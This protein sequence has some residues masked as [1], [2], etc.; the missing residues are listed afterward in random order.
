MPDENENAN[1]THQFGIVSTVSGTTG[2]VIQSITA[3]DTAELAEARG[4]NGE[5]LELHKFSVGYRYTV[6]GILKSGAAAGSLGAGST[7]TIDG[8]SMIVETC[9]KAETNNGFV[10]A[11]MTCRGAD[12]ATITGG[13]APAGE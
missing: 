1:G 2:M 12:S 5:V 7:L 9:S 4:E 13:T 6:T 8:H 3:E 10:T 11:T